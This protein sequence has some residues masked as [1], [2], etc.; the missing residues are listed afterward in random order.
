VGP[1]RVFPDEMHHQV[2]PPGLLVAENLRR[3][4]GHYLHFPNSQVD[5]VRMDQGQTDRFRVVIVLTMPDL[6]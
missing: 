5:M 3:L 6:L 2:F 1:D 4:A